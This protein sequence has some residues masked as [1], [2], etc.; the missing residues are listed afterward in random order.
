M[1]QLMQYFLEIIDPY[2]LNK[3]GMDVG[4]KY[5]TGVYSENQLHLEEAKNYIS[6]RE[7]CSKIVVEVLPLRNYVKSTD[8]HQDRLERFPEDY[9]YC[10]IPK[11]M[12]YKYKE[13]LRD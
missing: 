4:K 6:N 9:R 5:R 1:D 10:H 8:E 2:S 11:S 7:D 13:S 3:Q 12:M